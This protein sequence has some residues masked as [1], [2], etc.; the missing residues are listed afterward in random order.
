MKWKVQSLIF[1]IAQ[2]VKKNIEAFV[3]T[4]GGNSEDVEDTFQEGLIKMIKAIQNNDYR[5]DSSL[6]TFLI[7]VCKNIWR[8]EHIKRERRKQ[9]ISNKGLSENFADETITTE[10][11]FKELENS[12]GEILKLLSDSCKKCIELWM[13]G[14]SMEEIAN[15]LNLKNANTAKNKKSRCMKE[16][17]Q[18]VLNSDNELIKNIIKRRDEKV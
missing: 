16:L 8:N 14:Y 17:R 2:I 6:S 3:L 18:I 9:I 11:H 4:T 7:G 1:I 15:D 10:L 13:Q 12:L 5:G